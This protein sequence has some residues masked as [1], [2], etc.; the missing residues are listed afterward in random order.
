MSME[1]DQ[2]AQ[3]NVC[4]IDFQKRCS[5]SAKN[6]FRPISRDCR[7]GTSTREC[8]G[9]VGRRDG[10]NVMVSINPQSTDRD[11]KDTARRIFLYDS[12]WPLPPEKEGQ[13]SIIWKFH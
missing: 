2:R 12:T 5:V 7:R 9:Y 13:I 6:I 1:P 4:K 8:Q 3:Y 10:I 11:L